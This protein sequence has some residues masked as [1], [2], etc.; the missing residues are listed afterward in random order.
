MER[1]STVYFCSPT[2]ST[3]FTTCCQVAVTGEQER[4]PTCKVEV[5]PKGERARFDAAFRR[6][7]RKG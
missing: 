3:F 7:G 6:Q 2:N 1:T 5:L 4:C